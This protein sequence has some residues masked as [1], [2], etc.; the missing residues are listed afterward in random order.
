MATSPA[1]VLSPA[2]S[3]FAV[4]RNRNFALMWMGQL[5]ST[6]GSALTSLAA[7]ILIFRLTGSALSM[8]LMLMA[9]AVPTLLVG[10]MAGVFVDRYDRKRIMIAANLIRAVLVFLIPFLIPFNIAWLYII[11][12]LSSAVGQFF[13][14]A[15]ESVLPEIA[16]E[17]E[18]AAANSMIAISSFGS[19]AIG[20]AA[21]GLIASQFPIQWCFYLDA[22]SFIFSAVCI[23][24]IRIAPLQVEGQTTVAA[25]ARNL[26]AGL[27]FLFQH[28]ILRSV[29][30]ISIVYAIAIGLWNSLLLPFSLRA[31]HANEF[32][33]G[34]QEGLTSVGFVIGSLIMAS[35]VDRLRE[36]QWFVISLAGMGLVG[37]AYAMS[38]S[39][40]FAIAM[41]M[42][43]GLMIAPFNIARRLV[44]Q[45]NTPR[46]M[47]GRVNS[48]LFVTRDI[49]LLLG[50][51]AVGLAD[52]IDVR[53]MMLSSALLTLATGALSSVMPGLGQ[54]AAEW[55]RAM[56]LLR[57]A[58]TGPGPGLGRAATLADFDALAGLLPSL[59]G[60]SARDRQALIAQGSVTQAPSGTTVLRHGEVS[61]SAYFVLSG[62]AVAGIAT[63]GGGYRSLSTLGPGDFFGEIAA[64][65][66]APRTANV[67][68]DEPTTLLQVPAKALRG[69]MTDPA[70]SQLFLSKMTERLSRTHT[71]DLPRLA[72][73]DQEALR[74]L[75]T[76]EPQPAAG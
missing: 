52:V 67:V 34:L 15:H 58:P 46:E 63:E 73:L 42:V 32:Q 64:L 60:L 62:R 57:A 69:L 29:F 44:V 74:D 22:L 7:S 35:L 21:S 18:L 55:K 5:V 59:S 61:D 24:L 11:V 45:R 3:P 38:T 72:G 41:V 9:T 6:A 36:G 70:L 20:F 76:P 33:Y 26:G 23:L 39:I 47:R 13:D 12:A 10:L 16:S 4:F 43:S 2:P 56:S 27:Q 66:G 37:A 19:T 17:Q 25:V 40:P 54:P 49:F 75:R 71:S 68:A 8:G 53:V 48:S 28:T 65:T 51:A 50:M 31:L 30:A 14:P 1:P